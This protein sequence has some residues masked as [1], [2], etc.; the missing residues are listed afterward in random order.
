M[1]V[2]SSTSSNVNIVLHPNLTLTAR[3]FALRV[4]AHPLGKV[5]LLTGKMVVMAVGEAGGE[6]VE[7]VAAEGVGKA[8]KAV[9]TPEEPKVIS[10]PEI[11]NLEM[12]SGIIYRTLM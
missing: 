3:F 10:P 7:Q 9:V 2:Q 6:A 5:T 12:Y 4:R 11:L 8:A 1:N